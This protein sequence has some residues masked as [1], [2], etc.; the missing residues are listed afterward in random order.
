[1]ALEVEM[2]GTIPAKLVDRPLAHCLNAKPW[3]KT[4]K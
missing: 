1:M 2:A 4:W 3:V